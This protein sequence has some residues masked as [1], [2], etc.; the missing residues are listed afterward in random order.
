MGAHTFVFDE[1]DSWLYTPFET[2]WF[3]LSDTLKSVA[4]TKEERVIWPDLIV[5]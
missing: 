5:G 4:R 1:L 2:E 3:H